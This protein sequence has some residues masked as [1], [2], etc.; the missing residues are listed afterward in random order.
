MTS[1]ARL[2]IFAASRF[3]GWLASRS[4][5][6]GRD[7]NACALASSSWRAND[8]TVLGGGA[9]AAAAPFGYLTDFAG[10][11]PVARVIYQGAD[12]HVWGGY[13]AA[14]VSTACEMLD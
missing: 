12:G 5:P 13:G 3:L 9:A 10:Q 11:G 4:S 6:S 7:S 2:V 1:K 8:L 14:V